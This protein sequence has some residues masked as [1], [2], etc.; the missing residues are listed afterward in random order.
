MISRKSRVAYAIAAVSSAGLWAQVAVSTS[1]AVDLARLELVN[2]A[3]VAT[4][5]ARGTS[6]QGESVVSVNFEKT[7]EERRFVALEARLQQPLAAFRAVDLR[8]RLTA[9]QPLTARLALVA[10]ERGGGAWFRT[11]RPLASTAV[12]R[13]LRAS[14][15][16]LKPTSFSQDASKQLEWDQVERLWIGIVVD[17]K[18]KG[19]F[20]F[21]KV[22]LTSEPYR[23]TEPVS[24][25][26]ADPAQWSVGADPAVTGKEMQGLDVDGA[27]CLRLNFSFPGGK[28]MYYIPVQS[29]EDLEYSAYAGLRFTYRATVPAG[30]DGLLVCVHEN[31][32]QFVATPPPPA[33][34]E[35]VSL[36]VPWSAFPLGG[37][38]RDDNG[39]LDVDAITQ[40]SV[41]VHGTALGAGGA[42]EIL[43]K[44]IEAVP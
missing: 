40:I 31:G 7:G 12:A 13:D 25:F 33:T 24:L 44:A 23:A 27:S 2:L 20:E 32:G 5:L 18:G 26:R 41:G 36:T 15:Q 37:W 8:Y 3:G 17:G 19:S 22:L 43:I 16:A 29:V 9:D 39:R 4:E 10:Y 14:L 34:G 6:E 11:S 28:H 1:S 21:S 38:T 42:G 30:V 35:W